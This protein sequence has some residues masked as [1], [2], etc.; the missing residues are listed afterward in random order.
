VR[1]P[2]LPLVFGLLLVLVPSFAYAGEADVTPL[3]NRDVLMMVQKHLSE[4]AIVNAIKTSPCTFDTFPPVLQ[5]MK[6]RGVSDVVLQA[7]IDAPY[8]PSLQTTVAE[9]KGNQGEQPIYHYTDQLQ[10]LGYLAPSTSKRPTR[11]PSNN[12][13]RANSRTRRQ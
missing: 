10:R 11:F 8:G 12:R 13:L 5:D 7:M 9:S 3:N 4:E 2:L 6:R 1:K